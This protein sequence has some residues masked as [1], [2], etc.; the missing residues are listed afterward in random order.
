MNVEWLGT[1]GALA[2][3]VAGHAHETFREGWWRIGWPWVDWAIEFAARVALGLGISLLLL[4]PVCGPED[5]P[6]AELVLKAC[7]VPACFGA[8][9]GIEAVRKR[10]K[11]EG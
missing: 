3:F 11:L 2:G 7:A 1:A 5:G 9:M 4:G 6:Y 8:Q 10:R